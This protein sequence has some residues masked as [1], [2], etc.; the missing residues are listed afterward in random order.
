MK[1]LFG[2]I[3][4]FNLLFGNIT[5]AKLSKEVLDYQV[6]ET[7][8]QFIRQTT[9]GE[10][11]LKKLPGY[12]VFPN[13]YKAGFMIGGEYGEGGMVIGGKVVEYYSMIS[14]SIGFQMG[15]QRRSMIIA[16]LAPSMLDSFRKSQKWK[17]GIDGSITVVDWGKTIDLSTVDFK[18]PIVAFVFDNEGLMAGISIDGAIFTRIQK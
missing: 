16:F 18:K 1:R 3:I 8:Q 15:A 9:G 12:L 4:V 13:I 7:V 10:E 2:Y 6:K 5:Y 11:F 14:A 17:V